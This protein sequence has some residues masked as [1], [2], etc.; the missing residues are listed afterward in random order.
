MSLTATVAVQVLKDKHFRYL[1]MTD[2]VR[3]IL[4]LTDTNKFER[5]QI[6]GLFAHTF[7]YLCIYFLLETQNGLAIFIFY[8]KLALHFQISGRSRYIRIPQK[9]IFTTLLSAQLK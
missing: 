4:E 3:T 2:P 1:G 5:N 8:C 7:I 6:Q 9:S